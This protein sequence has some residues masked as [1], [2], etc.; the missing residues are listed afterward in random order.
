MKRTLS[1]VVVIALCVG[2]LAG[3]GKTASQENK[4]ITAAFCT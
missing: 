2:L 3:C 4:K 1:L